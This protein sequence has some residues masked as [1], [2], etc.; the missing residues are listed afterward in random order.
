MKLVSFLKTCSDILKR[1]GAVVMGV[2]L[3]H[4]VHQKIPVPK[5]VFIH[6][7]LPEELNQMVSC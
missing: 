4:L 2:A 1:R 7:L 6:L 5:I 3:A